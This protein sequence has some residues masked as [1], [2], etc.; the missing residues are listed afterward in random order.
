MERLDNFTFVI[1]LPAC[2]LQVELLSPCHNLLVESGQGPVAVEGRIAAAQQVEI[3]SIDADDRAHEGDGR[4]AES[5]AWLGAGVDIRGP[6]GN[7]I[8]VA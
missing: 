2:H 6:F 8:S 3:G 4:G 1:G 7:R 5:A